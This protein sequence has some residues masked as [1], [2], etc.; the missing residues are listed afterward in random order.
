M[1][2]SV[3]IVAFENTSILTNCLQ[4]IEKYNDIG[5]ELEIIISDN[6]LSNDVNM[7]ISQFFPQCKYIKN[8]NIGFGAAN[9]RGVQISSG[10]YILF[11][12]PDTI[13]IE[14]I[15]NFAIQ[16]FELNQKLCFFGIKLKSINLKNNYSYFFTDKYSFFWNILLNFLMICNLFFRSKMYI[17]GADIFIKKETFY[18]AGMFDENLFMYFEEPDLTKRVF[19]QCNS[20]PAYF[21]EKSIVHLE[22]G[23]QIQNLKA[24]K[25]RFSR[26]LNSYEYYCKKW[27]I[28]FYKILKKIMLNFRIKKYIFLFLFKQNKVKETEVILDLLYKK[29]SSIK[30]RR[31][32]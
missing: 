32:K 3:I 5:D 26:F 30:K 29:I 31:F 21:S 27:N 28:D 1:K 7:M 2:L 24:T 9:N 11:L 15:F 19:I 6:S 18:K 16:K 23:T 8:G 10:K 20:L 22:G 17:S 13:L 25:I 12:N 14:P 4:S